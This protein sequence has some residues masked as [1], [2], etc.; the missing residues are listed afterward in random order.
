MKKNILYTA[1]AAAV[2]AASLTSCDSFLDTLPDNRAELN[3]LD[4]IERILVSAYPE[5]EPMFFGEYMSDNVDDTGANNPYTDRFVDQVYNWEDVTESDN[6]SPESFWEDMNLRIEAAN[7]ALAAIEA[8]GCNTTTE[9]AIRAEALLCRAYATFMLVNYFSN[10]YDAKD[11]KSLGV[12]NITEQETV[13]NPK[14]TRATV[15]ENY[16]AI[17]ADLVKALP[18]VSDEYYT[19]PKYHF[20]K[21]AAYAF[22]TRFYLF[23]GEWQKAIDHA[24]VVLGTNPATMLRDWQHM[25]TMTSDFQAISQH[26][27][28]ATLNSNLLLMTAYS[29]IGLA[30]GPYYVDK[31]YSHTEYLGTNE[32]INALA[33]LWGGTYSSYWFQIKRYSGTNLNAWVKWSMSYLFEYTDPVAGIGYR[34]TVY[35][36]FTA[37]EILLS[38]AE[39]NIMLG[40]YNAAAEDMTLFMQN[41]SKTASQKKL[42]L[43][44]TSIQEFVTALPYAY[45]DEAQMASSPKKHLH[46]K[47]A[48]EAEGSVQESM[49][50]LVLMMRRYETLHEGKRWFDIKRYGIEIPRRVFNSAGKPASVT[51][52]LKVDDPRRAV[53]IPQKVVEAGLEPNPRNAK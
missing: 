38:R 33:S 42:V 27:I 7:T 46:P 1:F 52:W 43:T 53:Q 19:Q 17:E 16:A 30:F 4:K 23:K 3:T 36:A 37:D 35:N 26:Y 2:A 49:I 34:K 45:S 6:A 28:D 31:R 39:A 20:N 41:I 48:L 25:S 15:L 18:D 14:Y 12:P 40:N 13:L 24:N 47:F 9:K 21:N 22:A 8:N 10:H 29:S 51:D 32:T 44:P 50:Q 11:D 5:H